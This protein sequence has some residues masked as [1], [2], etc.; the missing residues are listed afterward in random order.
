MKVHIFRI[1]HRYTYDPDLIAVHGTPLFDNKTSRPVKPDATVRVGAQYITPKQI[2][3]ILH[4]AKMLEILDGPSDDPDPQITL[5]P[6]LLPKDGDPNN[7]RIENLKAAT[8][9]GRWAGRRKMIEA[10]SGVMVPR[11]FIGQ[12]P[13]EMMDDLGIAL[14]DMDD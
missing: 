3:Y 7:I 2:V 9:N 1:L 8:V 11:E 14:R 12:M 4:R 5:P 10:S 13:Q 6:F